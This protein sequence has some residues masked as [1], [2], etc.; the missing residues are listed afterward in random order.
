M[1]NTILIGIYAGK[2]ITD[3]DENI[4]IGVESA[5]SLTSGSRNIVI[6]NGID[7]PSKDC[8][9]YVNIGGIELDLSESDN[10]AL[11]QFLMKAVREALGSVDGSGGK[12]EESA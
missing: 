6:G 1:K 11:R 8:V 10:E 3:G 12:T 7:V 9:G 5:M 2:N 4:V